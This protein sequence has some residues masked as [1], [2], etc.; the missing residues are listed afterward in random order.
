M[1]AV[2][3]VVEISFIGVSRSIRL[4]EIVF[5]FLVLQMKNKYF[6]SENK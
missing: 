6:M 2:A 3:M 5:D 1:T 4:S